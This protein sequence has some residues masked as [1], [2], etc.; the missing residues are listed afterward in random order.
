MS[1]SIEQRIGSLDD[2]SEVEKSLS[3]SLPQSYGKSVKSEVSKV[4]QDYF[5][6]TDKEFDRARVDSALAK[7]LHVGMVEHAVMLHKRRF[8]TLRAIFGCESSDAELTK[9][10][11]NHALIKKA[12]AIYSIT[13]LHIPD[14][15]NVKKS[16]LK[17][18]STFYRV[19]DDDIAEK[20]I[21]IVEYEVTKR[22]M[23]LNTRGSAEGYDLAIFAKSETGGKDIE[24]RHNDENGFP[25]F[26]MEPSVAVTLFDSREKA[27]KYVRAQWTKINGNYKKS[28]AVRSLTPS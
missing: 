25:G 1:F 23:L 7:A 28:R 27:E 17:V 26:L 6:R 5:F 21:K 3:K 22:T 2:A 20:G 24:F 16:S 10:Y 4:V 15:L 18:G 11:E 19:L 8:K 9:H 13:M 12:S 14:E